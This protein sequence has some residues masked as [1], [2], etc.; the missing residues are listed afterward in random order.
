MKKGQLLL[1]VNNIYSLQPQDTVIII[2]KKKNK[3]HLHPYM[4][5]AL[6]IKKG[7]TNFF[8]RDTFKTYQI[9]LDLKINYQGFVSNIKSFGIR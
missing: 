5:A 1:T 4:G 7:K 2:R 3:E 8:K 9:H 6:L